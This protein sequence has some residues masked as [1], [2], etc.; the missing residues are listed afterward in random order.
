MLVTKWRSTVLNRPF[1]QGIPGA[2]KPRT[3]QAIPT[4]ATTFNRT[5]IRQMTIWL[6]ENSLG[7]FLFNKSIRLL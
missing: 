2:T 4:D 6:T 7:M 1:Q 3:F 5:T